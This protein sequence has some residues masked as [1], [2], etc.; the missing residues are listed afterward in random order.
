MNSK[1]IYPIYT[2]YVTIANERKTVFKFF[3]DTRHF[4]LRYSASLIKSRETGEVDSL[5]VLIENEIFL[6]PIHSAQETPSFLIFRGINFWLVNN[7]ESHRLLPFLIRGRKYRQI[8]NSI[9]VLHEEIK[10][11]LIN[12]EDWKRKDVKEWGRGYLYLLSPR[13]IDKYA[14]KISR[15][16]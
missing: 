10:G 16:K 6:F 7:A 15:R 13:D 2:H 3:W 8:G 12:A 4:P 9:W 14:Y 1:K 5:L 11:L